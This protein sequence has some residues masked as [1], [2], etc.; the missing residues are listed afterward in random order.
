[1]GRTIRRQGRPRAR[2]P[3][4]QTPLIRLLVT[5]RA[6]RFRAHRAASR[7]RRSSKWLREVLLHAGKVRSSVQRAFDAEERRPLPA[8]R[9]R[10]DPAL[11]RGEILVPGGCGRRKQTSDPSA[12][13]GGGREWGKRRR[14]G[15]RTIGVVRR[16]DLAASSVAVWRGFRESSARPGGH[17][18][19]VLAVNRLDGREYAIKTV[20]MATKSGGPV[21]PP[22]LG[23]FVRWRR[24]L[25][26]RPNAVVRYNRPGSRRRRRR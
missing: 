25:A 7:V 14:G 2:A 19:V 18:R 26:S 10:P 13:I 4:A 15:R 1:M 3:S 9:R 24:S 16:R 23:F 5:V 21:S 6:E 17:G 8:R 12:R 20:R 22:P 11:K